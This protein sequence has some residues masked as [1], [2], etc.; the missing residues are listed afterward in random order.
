MAGSIYRDTRNSNKY[1]AAVFLHIERFMGGL[2]RPAWES[3]T[4]HHIGLSV[5]NGL[6]R[7][8]VKDINLFASARDDTPQALQALGSLLRDNEVIYVLQVPEITIPESLTALKKAQ[9]VQMVAPPKLQF[10]ITGDDIVGLGACDAPEML[11]LAALTQPGPFLANTHRMLVILS[12]CGSVA[13]WLLWPVPACA[14]PDIPKS[15]AYARTPTIG[16]VGWLD[17]CRPQYRPLSQGAVTCRSF[18]LG[19]AIVRLL[20]FISRLVLCI[21]PTSMSRS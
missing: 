17:D 15:V 13:G 20:L 11:E 8:Y 14:F 12:A 2:D 18:T 5:G 6:A 7:R 16:G 19:K 21:G 9:G 3:L 4:T 10:Q 1:P